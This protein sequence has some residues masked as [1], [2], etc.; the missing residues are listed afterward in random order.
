MIIWTVLAVVLGVALVAAVLIPT[1][2]KRMPTD[3]VAS[4]ALLTP[5]ERA[6]AAVLESLLPPGARLLCK[7]RVADVIKPAVNKD[8]AAFLRIS[9]KHLDFVVAS[10]DW[11]VQLV[12]ELNDKSHDARRRQQRDKFLR[13]AFAAAGVPLHFIRAAS[14]YDAGQLRDLI[15]PQAAPASADGAEPSMRER[16]A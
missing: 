8:R 15:F 16:R 5:G 9:Q 12:I 1:G 3:Y 4:P 14:R 6:F 2:R 11:K 7:V 13:D 10:R